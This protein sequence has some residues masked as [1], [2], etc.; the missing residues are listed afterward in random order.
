M[1]DKSKMKPRKKM[2]LQTL[3]DFYPGYYAGRANPGK[4]TKK[5]FTHKVNPTWKPPAADMTP[6]EWHKSRRARRNAA[7]AKKKVARSEARS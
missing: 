4:A 6:K 5:G 7:D 3:K 2:S 1:R